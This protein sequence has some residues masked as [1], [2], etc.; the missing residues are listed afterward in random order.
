MIGIGRCVEQDGV[1]G[2]D[3]GRRDA[4]QGVQALE[5][6]AGDLGGAYDDAASSNA[7]AMTFTLLKRHPY[8]R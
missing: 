2:D 5:P 4:T 3:R 6:A 8:L 7:A 1:V